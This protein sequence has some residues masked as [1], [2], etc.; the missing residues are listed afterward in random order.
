[1]SIKVTHNL[2]GGQSMDATSLS[3]SATPP[4][5]LCLHILNSATSS[6][7][8]FT[9]EAKA[10]TKMGLLGLMCTIKEPA[11]LWFTSLGT[12]QISTGWR[13]DFPQ[14]LQ[15]SGTIDL[16]HTGMGFL[17]ELEVSAV[18]VIKSS[19]P[20]RTSQATL[21]AQ[22]FAFGDFMVGGGRP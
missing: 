20:I 17:A 2:Q 5:P 4:G 12:K 21:K 18:Y 7:L 11:P 6:L 14:I 19:K 15:L 22:Y 9:V 1:M 10:P 8:H 13:K 3:Y 16:L